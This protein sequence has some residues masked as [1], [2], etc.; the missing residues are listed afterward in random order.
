MQITLLQKWA[1]NPAEISEKGG[2]ESIADPGG[3][4]PAS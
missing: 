3:V 2:V 4:P 1:V